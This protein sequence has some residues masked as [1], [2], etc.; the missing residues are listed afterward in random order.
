M[1]GVSCCIALCTSFQKK[2][3]NYKKCTP[4]KIFLYRTTLPACREI[5]DSAS[6][7]EA[8]LVCDFL[9]LAGWASFFPLFHETFTHS[10]IWVP[11]YNPWWAWASPPF[12]LFEGLN[13]FFSIVQSFVLFWALAQ[14][15][16]FF[17]PQ[18]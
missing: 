7:Y 9:T 16:Q 18:H 4:S 10:W 15:C 8:R 11:P 2:D 3:F 14:Y 13:I 17:R 6:I 12:P 1:H 5:E